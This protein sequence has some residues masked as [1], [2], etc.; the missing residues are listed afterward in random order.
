M[1]K[2]LPRSSCNWSV[3][4]Q[5][6][7]ARGRASLKAKG[8]EVIDINMGCPAREVTGKAS[9]S[10]LMRD[11]D[12]ALSL[13]EAVVRAVTVPVTL[14]MRLGWDDKTRNAPELARRAE[15]AGVQ[16]ITVH[17]RTRQQFF[18]GTADWTL[19]A[20]VKDAVGIPV[21]VNGDITSIGDARAALGAVR[22]RRRHDRPRAPMARRGCLGSI[23]RALAIDAAPL[24]VDH[25]PDAL[26]RSMSSAASPLRMWKRCSPTTATFS[27]FAMRASTS[28]GTSRRAG[29]GRA[30]RA[31]PGGNA[32]AR[33]PTPRGC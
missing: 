20:A 27:A 9:G 26:R 24:G 17:G 18:K 19:C 33:R 11:L 31:R 2:V 7:W 32:F 1:V 22:R 15:A 12:H 14:K 3:P 5:S 13:V 10:A 29:I 21:I 16:L 28:A 6:G 30:G 25:E 23:A 8:A 4:L